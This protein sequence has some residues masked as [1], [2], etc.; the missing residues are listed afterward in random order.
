MTKRKTTEEFRNELLKINPNIELIGEY[1]TCKKKI[2][3]KDVRC[4]HIWDVVP[5]SLLKGHGCPVCSGRVTKTHEKFIEEMEQLHPNIEVLSNYINSQTKLKCR[6]KICGYEWMVKPNTLL[7]GCGCGKCYGLYRTNDD[8]K[9]QLKEL[10]PYVSFEGNFNGNY[11]K[12][13]FKCSL[14]GTEWTDVPKNVLRVKHCC[15]TC[16]LRTL[17]ERQT[18]T[19]EY[20]LERLQQVTKT[21]IPLERYVHNMTP[22]KHKCLVCGL[23]WDTVPSNLLDSG[24]CPECSSTKGESMITYYLKLYNIEFECQKSFD[25]LKYKNPLKYDFYLPNNNILI[26]YD[27]EFHYFPIFSEESFKVEKIR[28]E[29]KTNYAKENGIR[30]IRIPYWEFENI[31]NILK[32]CLQI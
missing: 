29:I 3:V 24:S 14:D 1:V 18:W 31:E 12:L 32:D 22:I 8:F 30:L 5:S 9:K 21:I 26:E 23:E 11:G 4:G 25:G 28:D 17:S 16:Q 10:H 7:N 2:K 15:L 19:H 6:C 13:K 27:G 20:Y